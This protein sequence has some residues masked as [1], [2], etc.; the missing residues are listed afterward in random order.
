MVV[1]APVFIKR[2]R[3]TVPQDWRFCCIIH[4]VPEKRFMRQLWLVDLAHDFVPK[5][6]FIFWETCVLLHDRKISHD[7]S[8]SLPQ[9][10]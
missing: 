7:I 3:A 2:K 6:P 5:P 10:G 1:M 4:F 8:T 9:V